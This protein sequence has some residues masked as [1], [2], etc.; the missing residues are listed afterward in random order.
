MRLLDRE[1][2]RLLGINLIDLLV[3]S[4]VLFLSFSL[5]S[6]LLSSNLTFT[7]DQMYSAIQTYQRL[8]SKGFLI[9]AT[10]QGRWIADETEAQIQGILIE[11]RSGSFALKDPE[12]QVIWIGGSMSYL[13]DVAASEIVFRPI[14][15]YVAIVHSDPTTFPSYADFL[16][17]FRDQ[18]EAMGADYLLLTTDIS[19]FQPTRSA[20]DIFN[21]LDR[22][23]L[24]KY[25]GIV[26]A[27]GSEYIFRL[28]LADLS[29]LENLSIGSGRVTIAKTTLHAGYSERPNLDPGIRVASLEDLL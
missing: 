20:Q 28:K 22:S 9:E 25:V 29:A 21:A 18:K 23:Y 1:R 11:T 2:G 13:E 3:L 15:R 24:L 12:G 26:Q 8:D 16:A 7:G 17:H 6:H 4:V 14:D 19:F 27:G 5:L 10:V